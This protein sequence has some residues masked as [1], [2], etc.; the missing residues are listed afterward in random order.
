MVKKISV[1]VLAMLLILQGTL[2]LVNPDLAKATAI[3]EKENIL[4]SV[5]LTVVDGKGNEVKEPVHEQGASVLIE[6]TWALANG[7]DYKEGDTF[8][9]K[10]PELFELFNDIKDQPLVYNDIEVGTFTVKSNY[11]VIMTF[12]KEI[13]NDEVQ[14]T[15]RIETKFDKKKITG[16]VEQ[17]IVFPIKDQDVVKKIV[18]KPDVKS[19]VEKAGIPDGYNPKSIHWTIDVNKKL[20]TVNQAVVTDAIPD[21]LAL[22]PGS[23]KVYGL[24]MK[25]DGSASPK[26]EVDPEKYE[27]GKTDDGKDFRISFKDASINSAYRIEYT[28]S[29]TDAAAKKFLNEATLSGDAYKP[30]TAEATVTIQSGTP[31]AKSASSYDSQ[32]QTITWEIKYNYDEQSIVKPLLKDRFNESQELFGSIQ[33]N[34]ITLGPKGEETVVNPPLVEDTDFTVTPVTGEIGDDGKTKRNGFDLQFD[35]DIDSA[36]KIVYKTKAIGRVFDSEKIENVI[37][38][39]GGKSV[40][41]EKTIGQVV[42]TKSSSNVDYINKTVKWTIAI[43]GNNFPMEKA[44]V[45][46]SFLK[47]GLKFKPE[48]LVVKD[49]SGKALDASE[50]ELIYDDPVVHNNGFRIKFK[51]DVTSKYTI[52][53]LTDFNN[54]WI[55]DPAKTTNFENTAKIE[56]E[57]GSDQFSKEATGIFKPNTETVN[58]GFK[59]GSYNAKTKEI[60]W[61]IGINYHQKKIVNAEVV[62]TLQA[63]QT[64]IENT[65]AVREL[66]LNQNGSVDTENGA[67]VPSDKYAVAYDT[68]KNEVRIQFKEPIDKPYVVQFNTSLEGSL[69]DKQ[70]DNTAHLID[71]AQKVSGD[72]KASVNI[73]NGDIYAI[74]EG[75]Q[76]GERIHWTIDI[77]LTQ[78]HVKDAK[79]VDLPSGNQ[80]LDRDSFRLFTTIVEKDGKLTKSDEADKAL[81]EIKV[82]T[83]KDGNQSFELHFKQDIDTAYILEY[84]SIID[85]KNGDTVSNTVTFTGNNVTTV[86]KDFTEEIIVGVSSGSGSGSGVRGKLT[87]TKVDDKDTAKVLNGAE[88]TLH[89][90]TKAGRVF[91]DKL[92]SALDGKVVFDKLRS[93]DYILKEIKAPDGYVLDETEH[94]V[95]IDSSNTEIDVEIKNTKI[96][97]PTPTPKPIDPTPKPLDPTPTPTPTPGPTTSPTP[98]PTTSPTTSPTPTTPTTPTPSPTPT[99]ETIELDGEGIPKGGIP[100]EGTGSGKGSQELPKTGEDSVWPMQLAGAA[101][102]VL[103]GVLFARKKRTNKN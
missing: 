68:A 79:L 2:G 85:A 51:N 83:D 59:N 12:N 42:I 86:T 43:N 93:G 65:L 90:D 6:Y 103:G 8:S 26:D 80:L 35:Q 22:V 48:T 97:V 47:G 70:V 101:L 76:N 18:F 23:L 31:L 30:V 10:L 20:E 61:T 4:T 102:I 89:R 28:T 44:A 94:P 91:I 87:V 88:F 95:K 72:L 58:N 19:T 100:G 67:I 81:Y 98:T 62:D 29:I 1:W 99:E 3:E 5:N 41:G 69:I 32:T 56:W 74:K 39:P 64:F 49:K 54:E 66:I 71:G 57:E 11:E 21:G 96:L 75:T 9:F 14:G 45:T 25:L 60:T 73:P 13:E 82:A 17:E 36:Y 37:I 34:K 15:V 63:G 16:S 84:E 77:N 92:T 78:S 53:F 52:E 50:Y 33:I 40:K 38:E 7:H 46:D 27:V 55:L 24:D